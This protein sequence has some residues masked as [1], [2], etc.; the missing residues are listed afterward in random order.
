LEDASR[1]IRAN[2][3]ERRVP[4]EARGPVRH[5]DPFRAGSGPDAYVPRAAF[6]Q[7]CHY[8]AAKLDA[9]PTWVGIAGPPGVG[10][11]LLLR[12]LMQRLAAQLTPVYVPSGELAP[13]EVARWVAA[14]IGARGEPDSEVANRLA[15]KGRP[16]LLAIDE[17]QLAS[18]E[19]IAW[20]E[21]QCRSTSGVRAVL[22]WTEPEGE[23]AQGPLVRCP[24][25]VF[26]EPLE[27]G[28]VAAYIEAQLARAGA[29]PEQRAVL[30]GR[31]LDRIALASNGNPRIIQRLADA[32]RTRT[33]PAH[34][35][36]V[37]P[38]R[39]TASA[40]RGPLPG[41]SGAAGP[42]R[43]ILFIAVVVIALV[44]AALRFFR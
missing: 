27:L 21:R 20:I 31:T 38:E 26:V 24:T 36:G 5:V 44:G 39:A 34:V 42:W 29:T 32:W 30:G 9:E 43:P 1:D 22:A 6:E 3:V 4:T 28:E 2:A 23:R 25:R 19:L 14:Q 37:L 7:I 33:T 8:L 35:R 15:R 40:P 17:A 11:T 10:K 41:A 18:A 12:L 13:A 16:L